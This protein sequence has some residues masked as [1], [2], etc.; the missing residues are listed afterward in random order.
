MK[1]TLCILL[2]LLMVLSL[3]GC[4]ANAK[5]K[6]AQDDYAVEESYTAY[7][8]MAGG[9]TMNYTADSKTDGIVPQAEESL[10]N[11]RKIIYTAHINVETTDFEKGVTALENLVAKYGGYIA[12]S[13]VSGNTQYSEAGT[14]TIVN[15]RGWYE[16]NIPAGMLDAFLEESGNVGNVTGKNKSSNDITEAYSDTEIRLE[17]LRVEQQRLLEL[18]AKAD[19]IE[20]I[21]QIEDKLSQLSYEIESHEATKRSWDKQISFSSVTV[22]LREVELYTD[23]TYGNRSVWQRIGDSFV[24]GFKAFGRGIVNFFIELVYLLPYVIIIVAVV[25]TVIVIRK[26]RKKIVKTEN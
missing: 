11:D 17:T 23:V 21:I 20:A 24:G 18:L 15:R 16:V 14:A 9:S 26:K 13:D 6:V 7:S 8:D 3:F 22:N 25:I 4:G 12:N 5:N 19:T 10:L 1:K 2:A